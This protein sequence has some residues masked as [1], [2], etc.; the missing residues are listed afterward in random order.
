MSKKN[1]IILLFVI[2]ILFY[3]FSIPCAFSE[4]Y[5]D[6]ISNMHNCCYDLCWILSRWESD[7]IGNESEVYY[8]ATLDVS[9]Q[10]LERT[11]LKA[12]PAENADS[13]VTIINHNTN[14]ML[15]I[16]SVSSVD[17]GPIHYDF[18]GLDENI[19]QTFLYSITLDNDDAMSWC[20]TACLYNDMLY[21]RTDNNEFMSYDISSGKAGIVSEVP[22][23]QNRNGDLLY[24]KHTIPS[25]TFELCIEGRTGEQ[26]Q[27]LQLEND[28]PFYDTPFYNQFGAE[29]LDNEHLMLVHFNHQDYKLSISYF[30]MND[31]RVKP[32]DAF[33]DSVVK[34]FIPKVYAI[35]GNIS[36]D[37]TGRYIVFPTYCE[38]LFE[39]NA[40]ILV[41]LLTG[42][43]Y[44]L[45]QEHDLSQINVDE[46]FC[47]PT[48]C[49][50]ITRSH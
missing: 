31:G 40:L 16:M 18:Y 37:P 43:R 23:Q 44:E 15:V 12:Q 42:K 29:W 34:R 36:I 21:Y 17:N 47:P 1:Y 26:Y 22:L 49:E 33:G 45:Y 28:P 5:S 41:D 39:T 13:Y 11:K 8:L 4:N 9:K 2:A 3:C 7:S 48:I 50:W 6:T 25:N 27:I 38:G 35:C 10:A 19:G 30:D 24:V 14:Y 20:S 32:M 46:A